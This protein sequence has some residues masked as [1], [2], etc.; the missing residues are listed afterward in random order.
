M[1]ME[2]EKNASTL[3]T[4]EQ[5][6]A[7]LKSRDDFVIL[8]HASPDGD[9]IGSAA[10]LG[11][12]LRRLGKRTFIRCADSFPGKF[13]YIYKGLIREE[14]EE[15]FTPKTVIAS[16]VA[17][18]KLLG[19]LREDYPVVDLCIDHH[20]SNTRYAHRLLLDASASATCEIIY[21]LARKLAD[22]PDK[23]TVDALFTGLSTDT[24]CFKFSNVTARTHRIAADLLELG[25]DAAEINRLM[26]DTKSRQRVEIERMALD[27]M[28]FYHD[29]RCAMTTITKAMREQSRCAEDDLEGLTTLSRTIEGVIIG[30]TIREKD[31]GRYKVSVRTL[32]PVDASKLCAELGGG[33]HTRAAGCELDGPLERV[34]ETLAAVSLRYLEASAL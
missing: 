2:K 17:D 8:C 28:R 9:T 11:L 29:G 14:T 22:R 34:R 5:T 26:F 10:G 3:L 27:S 13:S 31:N 1:E 32:A 33:G 25:A 20:V 24:G 16:D 6:C 12:V 15:I 7:F 30:I 4:L 21:Q 23:Q 18:P 19:K